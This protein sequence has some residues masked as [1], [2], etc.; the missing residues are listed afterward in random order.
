MASAD[1]A[2]EQDQAAGGRQRRKMSLPGNRVALASVALRLLPHS[3][4]I[5]AYLRWSVEGKTKER[6]ISEVTATTRADNLEAAWRIVHSREL[7]N[8]RPRPDQHPSDVLPPRKGASAKFDREQS[9]VGNS[10]DNP[11]F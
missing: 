2:R 5:Y 10:P 4:R 11:R 9:A 1:R 8:Q 3:R 7:T 6:Y